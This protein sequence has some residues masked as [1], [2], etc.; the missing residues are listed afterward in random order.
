V[1]V[2]DLTIT[3]E[4]DDAVAAEHLAAHRRWFASHV[5]SGDFLLLGPR[6]DRSGAGIILARAESR[7]ALE[8]IL[9]GDV[10]HP[11]GATYE[12][13]EFKATMGAPALAELLES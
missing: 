11:E 10:Y 12:V 8:E 13:A 7:A 1:F 9:A 3:E 4:V 2:I 6:R 5:E